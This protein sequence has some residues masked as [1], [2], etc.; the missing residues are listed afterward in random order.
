MFAYEP[1][2]NPPCNKW[3][4][5]EC[6]KFIDNFIENIVHDIELK[7]QRTKYKD[8]YD[9][10]YMHIYENIDKYYPEERDNLF[11]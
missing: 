11:Y 4:E 9:V 8:L 5:Y 7:G 1:P 6:P 10:L 3:E 2:L